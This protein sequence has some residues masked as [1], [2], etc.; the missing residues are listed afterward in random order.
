MRPTQFFGDFF[1]SI[2]VPL[3]PQFP[4]FDPQR[5]SHIQAKSTEVIKAD[6]VRPHYTE[7]TAKRLK[8][9]ESEHVGDFVAV[10]RPDAIRPFTMKFRIT[11][12]TLLKPVEGMIPIIVRKRQV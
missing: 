3:E 2:R 12:A 8:H 4:Q 6:G 5:L 9:Y 11:A 10:V 7:F 1:D